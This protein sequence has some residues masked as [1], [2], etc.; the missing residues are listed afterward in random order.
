M[1]TFINTI[2]PDN[3]TD[4]EIYSMGILIVFSLYFIIK[5]IFIYK[6]PGEKSLLKRNSTLEKLKRLPWDDFER[7]CMELFAKQGW[8]TTGN[9]KKGAD[10]GVDIWMKK[11]KTKSIVQC[12]RYNKTRV[13]VKVVREMYGLMYEYKVDKAYIVTTSTF[14]RDCYKFVKNKNIELINGDNLVLLIKKLYK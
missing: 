13:T 11:R 5:T 3:F 14:T 4:Y 7:L 1:K 2:F 12:K 8:S 6:N 9:S 10:G